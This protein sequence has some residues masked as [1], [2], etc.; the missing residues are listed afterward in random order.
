MFH[1]A[2]YLPDFQ[3]FLPMNPELFS[4]VSKHAEAIYL[5]V[6]GYREHL[7]QFPELSYQEFETMAFVSERLSELGIP[8]ETKIGGT[9]VV[10]IIRNERHALDASCVALRADLDALPIQEDNDMPYCSKRPGIMHAC[11]HDF[12]TATLLGVAELLMSIKDELPHPVK[13]IFQP[14]EERNPGGATLMIADAVLENPKVSHLFALHVF[15]DLMAGE[16]GLKGGLYM[17]SCDEIH[18]SINGIGGHGAVPA[19]CVNPLS[20]AAEII[21]STEGILTAEKPQDVPQVISFGRMEAL[22]STNVIPSSAILKGTFRTMDEAW[23]KKA[24]GLMTENFEKLAA[25]YG[26]TI[27]VDISIGYPFL[28][29]DEGL[30]DKAKKSFETFFGPQNVIDLPQR[31]TSEDFSF[32][33]QLAPVCFYRVGVADKNK[34]VNYG[35]HHPKFDVDPMSLLIAMKSFVTCA[36]IEV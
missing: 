32:Y 1:F 30:T 6:K 8:H 34:S 20:I 22:G 26:G 14:G 4:I 25:K 7:H 2:Y 31:M 5:K 27:D 17:A 15:P 23:R 16:L 12:H 3:R 21:V 36:F 28:H 18:L 11:G 13:L 29:N 19:K 9:G 10:G 24:H 35:V 33:S